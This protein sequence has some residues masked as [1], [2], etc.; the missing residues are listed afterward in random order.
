MLEAVIGFAVTEGFDIEYNFGHSHYCDWNVP[1]CEESECFWDWNNA[2][3]LVANQLK[4]DPY[5][6]GKINPSHLTMAA[7]GERTGGQEMRD[8]VHDL[9]DVIADS[10]KVTE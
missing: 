5:S 4:K 8:M 1:P 3:D 9:A 2:L 6:W 10:Q 7:A